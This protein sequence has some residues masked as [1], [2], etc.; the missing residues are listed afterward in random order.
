MNIKRSDKLSISFQP[1]TLLSQ[2]FDSTIV[3]VRNELAVYAAIH[4][5]CEKRLARFPT[6]YAYSKVAFKE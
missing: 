4:D 5:V 1:V 2:A 6:R 3:S